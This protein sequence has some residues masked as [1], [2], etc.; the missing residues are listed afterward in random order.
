MGELPPHETLAD[1]LAA[2]L[3][4]ELPGHAAH[5][6]MAPTE[7]RTEPEAISVEGKDGRRAATLVLLY[8]LDVD[9]DGAMETGLVLTLRRTD[10]RD[11]SGQISLP[12]GRLENGESVEA[13]ALREGFEEVSLDPGATRVLGRLT[14]MFIPPSG[15]SVWPVV[16]WTP[17]RPPFVAQEAEVAALIEVPLHRLLD[18]AARRY[19][20]RTLHGAHITVPYFSLGGY[21]VWGATAMM[22][23]EF[24]AVV[25]SLESSVR[26]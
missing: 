5:A 13:A 1:A 11:H 26:E 23:A 19:A 4:A 7:R 3:T 21:E 14:P 6:E 17:T 9:A 10:L 15:F 12:G 24:V 22:L 25:R 2:R 18:D 20:T 8:P 16:G